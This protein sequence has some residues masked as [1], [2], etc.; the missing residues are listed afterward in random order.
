MGT[1]EGKNFTSG[2]SGRNGKKYSVLGA[3]Q[4]GERRQQ[5]LDGVGPSPQMRWEAGGVCG[6]G[7]DVRCLIGSL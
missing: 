1:L 5:S 7:K 2:V 4:R 3:E 6:T